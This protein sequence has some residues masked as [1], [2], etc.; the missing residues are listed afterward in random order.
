MLEQLVGGER[1]SRVS[2]IRRRPAFIETL[3][4]EWLAGEEGDNEWRT[5]PGDGRN[6]LRQRRIV[7]GRPC[8]DC[9]REMALYC[10]ER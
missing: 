2:W 6:L 7:L 10:W 8:R 4:R 3:R 1:H 9:L 5:K